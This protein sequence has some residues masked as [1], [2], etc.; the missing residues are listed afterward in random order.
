MTARPPQAVLTPVPVDAG[1]PFSVGIASY[2][3]DHELTLYLRALH[4]FGDKRLVVVLGLRDGGR[5]LPADMPT[6]VRL[7]LTAAGDADP[8]E[9]V[10]WFVPDP[11]GAVIL[12][13][14]GRQP[15][16]GLILLFPHDWHGLSPD[17][18]V[19]KARRWRAGPHS[20]VDD[21]YFN[22]E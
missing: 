9:R 6:S 2:R 5:V 4:Q 7:I 17:E 19:A 15:Q 18:L 1:E 10:G 13:M 11:L 21:V 22:A 12:A 20:P 14:T 16:D 3:G 8:D